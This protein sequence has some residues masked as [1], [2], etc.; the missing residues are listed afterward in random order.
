MAGGAP[1]SVPLSCP[2]DAPAAGVSGSSSKAGARRGRVLEGGFA[3]F[4][5]L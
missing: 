1:A 4:L 2:P 3:R 5:P